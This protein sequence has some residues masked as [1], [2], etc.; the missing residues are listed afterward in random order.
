MDEGIPVD[1]V[2]NTMIKEKTTTVSETIP[3]PKMI[4]NRKYKN[5]KAKSTKTTLKRNEAE[6]LIASLNTL[7]LN[8]GVTFTKEQ[9]ISVNLFTNMLNDIHRF[10]V[11]GNSILRIDTTFELVDGLWLTDTTYANESLIN[12]SNKHP[13][14]P[15]PSFWHF[16][17]SRESYRRFTGELNN[18][19]P[20]LLGITRI[21]HDLDKAIAG[22][23]TDVFRDADNVWCTQHSQ[24]RDAFKLKS[25]GAHER[26]R[27]RIMT[28]IYGS[29]DDILLQNGSAD[30]DDSEDFKIKLASLETVWESLVPGFH[31]WFTKHRS[32]QFKTC[33]VLSARQNLGITGRFYTN[34]LELKHRLQKKRLREDEIPKESPMSHQCWRSG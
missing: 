12:Q 4:A 16:K 23:M 13:E 26:S 33:L 22:G 8:S 20:E 5:M 15:G 11:L 32:E 34:G 29:H 31:R 18:A 25:L 3:G 21:G 24:E 1:K 17:K 27:N 6:T 7:P 19:K 30:A 2:Y 28:D 9:Y 10:C 14:F